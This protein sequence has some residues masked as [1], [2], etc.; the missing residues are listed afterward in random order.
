VTEHEG[1]EVRSPT[2]DELLLQTAIS[3]S[4]GPAENSNSVDA[5]MD[6]M[7]DT[8]ALLDDLMDA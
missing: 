7:N 2:I 3:N 6:W 5:F 1:V 8:Y 4:S